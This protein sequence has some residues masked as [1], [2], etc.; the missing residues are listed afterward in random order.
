MKLVVCG[1]MARAGSTVVYQITE[2]LV[3][4]VDPRAPSRS[5]FRKCGPLLKV[6]R[7]G[8]VVVR[9]HRFWDR[10]LPFRP[11]VVTCCRD[12]RALAASRMRLGWPFARVL[13]EYPRQFKAFEQ[14][15]AVP[16]ALVLRY[17]TLIKSLT[18]TTQCIARWLEISVTE[19]QAQAIG[20]NCALGHHDM[21]F[22][23]GLEATRSDWKR[24]LTEKQQAAIVEM[25]REFMIRTKYLKES[26]AT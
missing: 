12:P 20:A 8:Y 3:Y 15:A 6:E 13:Q 22:W 2:Q 16:G 18:R 9:V 21:P 1:G 4:L 17:E 11:K 23:P 5:G 25:A 14:W 24:D 26:Q 7:P 19:A 10:V